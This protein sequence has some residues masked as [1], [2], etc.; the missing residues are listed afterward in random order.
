MLV[1]ATVENDEEDVL[2]ALEVLVTCGTFFA[3]VEP[4]LADVPEM[5]LKSVHCPGV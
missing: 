4:G 2:E 1:V 5:S 3:D